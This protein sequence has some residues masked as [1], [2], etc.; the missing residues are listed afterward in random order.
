MQSNK[1]LIFLVAGLGALIVLGLAAVV[2]GLVIKSSGP[3]TSLFGAGG[4]GV[5]TRVTLPAGAR[6]IGITADDGAIYAHIETVGGASIWTIDPASGRVLGKIR[7]VSS[8][9]SQ[10]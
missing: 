5:E 2:V 10:K 9:A 6:V 4:A 3:G 7:L 8:K 1:G